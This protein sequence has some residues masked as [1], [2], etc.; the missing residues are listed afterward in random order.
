[1][2]LSELSIKY[3]YPVVAV[4][5]LVAVMG[6]I[7]YVQTPADLF[8]DTTPPQVVVITTQ[9]GAR[10]DDVADNITEVIE[11]EIN[12]I[13]GLEKVRST[14]RD[15]VSSIVAEFDYAKPLGEAVLDVQSVIA[16]VRGEL[17]TDVADPRIFRLTESTSRPLLTLALSAKP[18][19]DQSL[20]DIRL[21]AEN[22]LTDRILS[23][24]HIADVDVFGGHKPEIQVRMDRDKLAAHGLSIDD[25]ATAMDG[26]NVAIP[27]G[28]IYTREGEYLV[29]TNGQ[30]DRPDDIAALPILGTRRGL[31]RLGNVASIGLAD[32]DARSLYHGNG[33]RAIAMG[34]IGAEDAP[35]VAAIN[36]V[37]AALPGLE[38]D[39]PDIHFA[40]TQDQQPLIDAN[41][42]GMRNSILQAIILTVVVIFIFLADYRAAVIVSI[43]IPLAFLFSLGALWVTPYSLNM[44]TLSGLIVATGMV[45]DSSVVVLENI[46][47]RFRESDSADAVE[48]AKAGSREV[49]LAVTTG[50]LTTLFV[51]LPV[52]FVGG[53]AQR[54]M[55]RV[56]LVICLTLLA[57]LAT[58][59]T[60]VPLIASRL[61]KSRAG[62]ANAIERFVG[63]FDHAVDGLWWVYRGMLRSALR[64]RLVTLLLSGAFVVVSFRV[65][66]PLIGQ[67]QMP[68]MDTGISIVSFTAPATTRPQAFE[69]IL[70]RVE[71][72]I[73]QKAGVERVSSVVGS[74]P[75]ALAFGAGGSTAQTATITVEMVNRFEREDSIWKIQERWRQQIHE[76]PGIQDIRI[77]EFGATPSATTK[78]PVDLVISGSDARV[79]D[80]L[81]D[82]VLKKLEGTPGLLDVRRSWYFD[83]VSHRITVDS[84]LARVHGTSSR[85]IGREVRAAV[86]G[87]MSEKL[88]LERYLDI[89]VRVQYQERDINAPDKLGGIYVNSNHGPIPLRTVAEITEGRERPMITRENLQQTIDITGVNTGYTIGQVSEIIQTQI[90]DISLPRGYTIEGQ[91]S[92]AD[93]R[94]TMQRMVGAFLTGLVLLFFLLFAAFRSFLHPVTILVPIPLGVAGG[95]WGLLLFDMPRAMPATMGM[96]FLAGVLI[97]NS[98]LLVDFILQRRD[99]GYAKDEAI[100]ESVR[101][102]LR[103]ILM[104][105]ASTVL[106]LSPL[107]FANAVGLERMSPLAVMAG[108]GLIVG[109]V[110]TL[111]VTPVTYSTLDSLTNTLRSAGRWWFI[112]SQR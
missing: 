97:N 107:A 4:A 112:G 58:A 92:I 66:T 21:L 42:N 36:N 73:Q 47:R 93:I 89:P 99:R 55:G 51:L 9:P 41:L 85:Q 65:V 1:M 50:M 52:V 30:F 103:P 69:K 31:V 108:I 43:S 49:L 6:V 19:S 101:L 56:S 100:I 62:Q 10:A 27:G 77:N 17:P 20:R 70:N 48:S 84:A 15:G 79:L 104:T 87:V 2:T 78:A 82:T 5:L 44:V 32:A 33:R 111:V 98:V 3:P 40:I 81:A 18:R 105:T 76:V 22:Q 110:F 14:S 46:Y 37:K 16:R 74:E 24:E 59:V 80:Q 12:T 63:L 39:Y 53:Y 61:L 11:K 25:I 26:Q 96:I 90:K 8:P 83:K 60:I 28:T 57:S 109:T 72:I 68:P 86:D 102:R 94:E 35:T 7:G 45:V 29:T 106:G 95:L 67:E 64:W 71:A 38:A 75:G 13:S 54:T 88:R 91:G 34:L 23:I